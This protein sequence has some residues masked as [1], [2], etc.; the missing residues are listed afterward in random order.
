M[1]F[2]WILI[3]KWYLLDGVL[4]YGS[5]K[6]R[7]T[8][9]FNVLFV[10]FNLFSVKVFLDISNKIGV[11]CVALYLTI[12]IHACFAV[13]LMLRVLTNCFYF[14]VTWSSEIWIQMN[15]LGRNLHS[16]CRLV[17]LGIRWFIL[18]GGPWFNNL[19]I[20]LARC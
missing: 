18:L 8:D 9:S 1:N 10:K 16:L 5:S 13:I 19:T 17:R 2:H 14:V 4:V 11:S 7:L 20:F 12:F 6:S 15:L 3:S